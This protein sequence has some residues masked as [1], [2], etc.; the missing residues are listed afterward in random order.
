[1]QTTVGQ[2]LINEALPEHLRDYTRVLDKKGVQSLLEQV[3]SEGDHDVY[4]Q[5]VAALHKVGHESAQSDGSS[6]SI[7][8]LKTPP[9]TKMMME[10]LKQK[11]NEIA[12]RTDLTDEQKESAITNVTMKATPVIEQSMTDELNSTG[13]PFGDQIRSGSRGGKSDMRSMLVG[14]LLVTDHRSRI[15]PIPLL[16]GYAS[17]AAP[18]EYWAAAYGA[19][20]G[21]LSTKLCLAAGTVVL[22]GVGGGS[23]NIENLVAGDTVYTLDRNDNI[24][25]TTVTATVSLGERACREYLFGN[26]EVSDAFSLVATPEHKLL[27]D[28]T[29]GQISSKGKTRKMMTLEDAEAAG[30]CAVD[31]FD[32]ILELQTPIEEEFK[33]LSARKAKMHPSR[34]AGMCHVYDIEVAHSS[35]RFILANG[36]VV[37]NSTQRAGFFGKQLVQASHKQVITESDCGTSRGIPVAADDPDNVGALLAEDMGDFKAGTPINPRI[38]KA[39]AEQFKDKQITVRSPLTCESGHGLCSKCAGIRERG[40]LPAVGDNIGVAV[41]QALAEQLS[42]SSLGEK[43]CIFEDTEVM[44]SDW[45]SKR[46]KDVQIGD[47]VMG[48][49][50]TGKFRPVCVT[51]KYD[52]GIREC[53]RTDFIAN[54]HHRKVSTLLSI[55]STKDHQILSSRRVSS[56]DDEILN[57][58]IRMMPIGKVSKTFYAAA[59]AGFDDS[60]CELYNEPMALLI[61]LVLGDGCYTESVGGV[62]FSA[63]DLGLVEDLVPYLD[64]LNLKLT[65]LKGHKYYYR[66]SSIRDD[67]C[68]SRRSDGTMKAEARNPIK[69]YLIDHGMYGKYAHEKTLPDTRDWDNESVRQLIAGLY[70]T[71]G[72]V[73]IG[74]SNR[75]FINLTSTSRKLLEQ[76]AYLLYTRFGIMTNE[77]NCGARAGQGKHK[78][79]AYSFTVAA[80]KSVVLFHDNIPLMGVKRTLLNKLMSEHP[81]R[82]KHGIFRGFKRV[83]QDLVG[84]LPTYDLEVDHP[85]HLF[86]LANGLIVSNSG[87][88]AKGTELSGQ[89]TGFKLVNQLVQVPKAFTGGAAIAKLDGVV[90]EVKDAPQGGKHIV[91]GDQDHYV[92]AGLEINVKPGTRVEQGDL[93]SEGLPNPS[94][95]VEH[96]GLGAGRLDFVN[97][98]RDAYKKSN[99]SA[100][101]RNIE[102][103]ARGLINHVHVTEPDGIDNAIPD[104]TVEYSSIERNYRPRYGFKVSRPTLA[105]GQYLERPSRQYTIGTR[106]TNRVAKDLDKSGVKDITTHA[107]PPPF[108]PHMVRAME[109]SSIAPD[110]QTRMGG[111]YLEKGLM[112]AL[113]TGVPSEIHSTSYIPALARGKGFGEDLET[114]GKY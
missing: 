53:Y 9:R 30:M 66:L 10:Q 61:G 110:W 103:M 12:E 6:F 23:K 62:H 87:G 5:V 111:S 54:G 102:V 97:L 16:R 95:L 76:V 20:R 43:H 64:G 100:N 47:M 90:R 42:Q 89:P 85:D 109:Q 39:L 98:F 59:P 104:D 79:D 81:D 14:D 114:T 4:R 106:I 48:S 70:I 99:L 36:L 94:E 34:D 65:K 112:D 24:V 45:S 60:T 96:K 2:V 83:A 21:T 49:D 113:H 75:P 107:D 73:Y 56:Q 93:L 63:A 38:H 29:R 15:I 84:M 32:K 80:W 50:L 33:G 28:G 78:H 11:T 105:I 1:M 82:T 22:C 31:V 86:V 37:S 108:K 17:G 25:T 46:I 55:I 71:D 77:I 58:V 92:P 8:H 40:T 101:R 19:R 26:S 68:T 69:R 3:A 35:H 51:N 88:R 91:I 27:V 72:S 18:A 13:N 67:L 74:Y 41:A 57:G 7:A 52:N 44:M